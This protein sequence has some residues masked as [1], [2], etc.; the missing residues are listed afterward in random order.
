MMFVNLKRIFNKTIL[1]SLKKFFSEIVLF[2]LNRFLVKIMFVVLISKK[3]FNKILF[4]NINLQK[5]GS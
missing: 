5:T 2:N 1:V 4:I 3:V